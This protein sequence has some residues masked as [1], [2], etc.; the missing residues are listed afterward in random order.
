MGGVGVS[1]VTGGRYAGGLPRPDHGWASVEV[2]STD[3]AAGSSTDLAARA[4]ALDAEHAAADRRSAF[5]LPDGIVY[6]DGNS[7][8]ALPIGVAEAVADATTRQWG[9]QLIRSWNDAG[10]WEANTRVGDRIGALV[11]AAPGQTVV[12][13]S[14]TTN[15]YKVV[16]AASRMHPAG[17]PRRTVLVDPDSFPTDLYVVQSAARLAGLTVEL[18]HPRDARERIAVLG[19]T[20]ALVVYSSLDYR[21]GALWDL[22]GITEQT[23]AAG[24]FA[25]WDLCHSAGVVDV[26]LDRDGADFAVGCGYKYLNGGPGAPSFVY[27]R[28]EHQETFHNPIAGWNGHARPFGME[29]EYDP[30]PSISRLRSGTSPLLS[31][32]ALEAALAAYD[33]VEVAAIRARSLSLTAFFVECLGRLGVD[34]PVAT[35]MDGDARGSQVSLRHPGAYAVVQALIAR[36]VVG[37]FREPDIL[38]LGFAPLYVS[39][40]DALTAA[41]QVAAVLADK[42]HERPEFTARALVT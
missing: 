42:E 24:G 37:D 29:R 31:L 30:A 7:L 26:Q 2:M 38:R 9:Q 40:A 33:G 16:V 3:N 12:T 22:A 25:C 19:D 39:H 28:T 4:A 27:V 34:L 6:L 14:T 10:W 36:G 20:L 17:G 11:G 35:P 13:D 15:L 5:Q 8:G 41:E 32:L 23:H 18:V 1:L 21:T